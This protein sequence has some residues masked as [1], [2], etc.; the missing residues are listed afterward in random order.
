[1][2]APRN[3]ILQGDALEQLRTLPDGCVQACVT[4]PPYWVLRDYGVPGQLGLERTPDEFV[5]RMVEVFLEVRRVL[6]NDGTCWVNMGDAYCSGTSAPRKPT[7]ITGPEVPASWSNRCQK[8]RTAAFG[9]IK[10]KDLIGMPWRLAFALQEVDWWLR[11]DIIWHKSNPMPESVTDR[12]TKSHEYLFLLTKSERYYYDAAAI[13]EPLADKTFTTFG[14]PHSAQGNDALGKVKSD[15]WGRTVGSRGPKEWKMPDG[16]DT[17]CGGA[18]AAP[19]PRRVK[20][21]RGGDRA[22]G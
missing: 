9:T 5:A 8:E 4:S 12:P 7:S 2:V 19:R 22:H 18:G 20:G 1:M 6:R 21:E 17:G 10:P 3:T 11:S 15:N 14:I 13:R 16:W